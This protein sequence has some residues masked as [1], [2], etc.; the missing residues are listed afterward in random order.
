MALLSSVLSVN[1]FVHVDCFHCR[2]T[3][4]RRLVRLS[5]KQ[6]RTSTRSLGTSWLGGRSF[7]KLPNIHMWW[8]CAN[9]TFLICSVEKA[10]KERHSLM[11]ICWLVP[12]ATSRNVGHGDRVSTQ[13]WVST[14]DLSFLH[15]LVLHETFCHV[16]E[17][18]VRTDVYRN[19][20]VHLRL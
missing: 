9:P 4:C 18:L 10:D 1:N 15:F 2:K 14:F 11:C 7:Q 12:R 13:V 17:N 5:P 8:V 19:F 3:Q 16:T 20:L 6:Q